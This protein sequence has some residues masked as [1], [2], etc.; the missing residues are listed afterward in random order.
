VNRDGNVLKEASFFGD[1]ILVETLAVGPP[2]A[3]RTITG[4]MSEWWRQGV[5]QM[6]ANRSRKLE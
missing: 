2:R 6:L 3:P 1:E 5:D 4:I